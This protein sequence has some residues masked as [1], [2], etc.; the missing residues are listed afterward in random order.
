MTNS[1]RFSFRWGYMYFGDDIWLYV[2]EYT[3]FGND[4]VDYLLGPA[5]FDLVSGS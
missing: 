1:L 5:K 4:N 2:Q 3:S